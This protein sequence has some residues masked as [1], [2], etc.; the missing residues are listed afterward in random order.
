MPL[1]EKTPA[2]STHLPFLD[3]LRGVAILMV[4]GCHVLD[5]AFDLDAM[6]WQGLWP[7]WHVP[8]LVKLLYPLQFGHLGVAVFFVISGLCIQLSWR[9]CAGEPWA[10]FFHRRFFRIYP[11]YFLVMCV[12]AFM[13]PFSVWPVN[14][15]EW[16][17]H[18]FMVHN[19]K[20]EWA[21]GI[22]SSF[23]SIAVE[24]QLYLVFPILVLL[25]KKW[26]WGVTLVVLGC[27]ETGLRLWQAIGDAH[28][29]T[30][31][32][33]VLTM[34]PVGFWFS[35]ALGA[36][37]ADH[38]QT[39]HSTVFNR[40]YLGKWL[41][42]AFGLTTLGCLL[43][44]LTHPLAFTMASITTTGWIARQLGKMPHQQMKLPGFGAL[45]AIGVVSYSLYLWHQPF[46]L[47]GLP[48]LA[49]HWPQQALLLLSLP[50]KLITGLF[51]LPFLLVLAGLSYQWLEQPSIILG[52][53]VKQTF[54][55]NRSNAILQWVTV[56][57]NSLKSNSTADI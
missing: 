21:W 30:G 6:R 41:L 43:T 53:L 13:P 26:N 10:A 11:P 14:W 9:K 18:L 2:V 33:F 17:T 1:L 46:L 35:W 31:P 36:W 5:Y 44:R 24:W 48:W 42:V 7:N 34:L 54:K 15:L 3:W 32:W 28:I 4:Y 12:F 22:N 50:G 45:S 23:W 27:M 49:N 39:R 47:K 20:P 51:L 25:K 16:V 37:L 19:L 38:W 52:R 8:W 57:P 55:K 56:A 29:Q 40:P